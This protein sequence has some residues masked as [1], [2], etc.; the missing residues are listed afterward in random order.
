MLNENIKLYAELQEQMETIKVQLEELKA[1]I[2]DEMGSE[3]K[4]TTPD[5]ITAQL[6]KKETFKYTDETA[7]I[8][9]LKSKGLNQFIIEK[10][11]TT[12]MNNELKKGMS[13]TEDLK[14]M[15][16]KSTTYSFSV[17]RA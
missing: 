5:G 9:Y 4:V 6:I 14:P 12:P 10:I 1:T 15:Y 7:M 3:T 16:T 8:S 2:T 11:N 17:K 13:L